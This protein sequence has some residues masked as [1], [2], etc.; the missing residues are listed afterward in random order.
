MQLLKTTFHDERWSRRGGSGPNISWAHGRNFAAKSAGGRV[1]WFIASHSSHSHTSPRT[2]R[3]FRWYL[4]VEVPLDERSDLRIL[5][6]GLFCDVSSA[7]MA[8]RGPKNC[9][10]DKTILRD[11]LDLQNGAVHHPFLK[12]GTVTSH[13]KLRLCNILSSWMPLPVISAWE[14]QG[15]RS[16]WDRGTRPPIF[17]CLDGGT[18][19][20]VSLLFVEPSQVVFIC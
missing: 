18:R 4:H 10:K 12:W 15:H 6:L 7:E 8:D 19:S 14:A 3:C 11:K 13:R 1:T 9:W 20:R 16:L 17:Q 2:N 5:T